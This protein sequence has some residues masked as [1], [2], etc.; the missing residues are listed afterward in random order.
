MST[1]ARTNRYDLSGRVAVITGALGALGLAATR[2]FVEAGADVVA[3]ARQADPR[4]DALRGALGSAGARLELRPAD[5]LDESAVQGLVQE[6][7]ARHGHLDILVNTVGG[8]AAGQSV[9]ETEFAAWRRMLTLNLDSAF[10]VSKHAARAMIARRWGRIINVSSRAAL[11]GRRN[12][13]AYAVAKGAVVTLTEAQA[14]ELRESAITVNVLLP[15]IIDSPAN[16]AAMPKADPSRWPTAE[17]VA[18]VMLFLASDDAG[19][20][21]GASIPVYGLA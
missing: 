17:E 13:A 21:S 11:S 10:L 1:P 19:L 14:E 9:A 8:Y 4:S 7:V 15:R 12:A 16:R 6:V 18:R 20:I 3:V 5:V 2:A